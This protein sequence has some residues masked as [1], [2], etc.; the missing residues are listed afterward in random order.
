MADKRRKTH[1]CLQYR[2]TARLSCQRLRTVTTSDCETAVLTASLLLAAAS[3]ISTMPNNK[4]SRCT[5]T[6]T[7][8]ATTSS[9]WWTGHR[10]RTIHQAR[11]RSQIHV[12]IP[13][14]QSVHGREPPVRVRELYLLC[15]IGL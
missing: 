9:G 13:A 8:L 6:F 7:Q 12:S 14:C 3:V 5:T 4:P 2:Q 15:H 1:D 11:H 10:Y